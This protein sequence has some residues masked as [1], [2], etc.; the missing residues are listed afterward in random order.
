MENIILFDDDYWQSLLPLTYTKPIAELRIGIL[1]IS[2]KW[3]L[4]VNCS[5]SYITQDHLVDKYPI[6]IS[7][8]NLVVN[9]RL[10]P[11]DNI[12]N[13][14]L[15]LDIN[16]ALLYQDNLIAA[17]LDAILFERLRNNEQVEDLN[18]VDISKHDKYLHLLS[19]PH[20][21]FSE[22]GKEISKDF[23]LLT[24]NKASQAIP[25]SC[26]SSTPENIFLAPG[27]EISHCI[28]NASEG[29]VYIGENAKVME[30][31]MIRGPFAMGANSIIK[32]GARIYKDTSLG[33][34][35]K[36]GGELKNVNFQA[37]SNKAHEGYLGNSVIGEWCNL[38]ADT[39]CSNLKNNYSEVKLWDYA[40]QSFVKTGLQFCGLIMGDHS[41]CGINTMFN[42]GTVVG[43]ACNLFG[44]GYPRNFIPS[45][46]WGGSK[47]YKTYQFDKALEVNELVMARRKIKLTEQDRGILEYV[48]K[49]SAQFRNWE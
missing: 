14:I 19:R 10:L 38:G 13:L 28:I 12:V 43:V 41:K 39:N 47:G 5:I 48:F 34:Y 30:G 49:N 15:Q 27:A 2:E 21:L 16:E 29:P 46:T 4:R 42:T 6:K 3:K 20:D 45:Y 24:D 31:T 11:N 44:S 26:L 33:P 32:M 22:N 8:N 23:R 25:D 36:V 1:T 17:R 9:S 18:G 40:K 7:N 35:C 37:Y